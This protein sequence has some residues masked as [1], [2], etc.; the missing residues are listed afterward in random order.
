[1]SGDVQSLR[2][3][4]ASGDTTV[5]R[6]W[7][8]VRRDG[9]RFGFTDH[10]RDLS[11]DGVTF[12]AGSGLSG[13]VIQ[14][15]TGLSVDN[16]AAL[17]TLS[18]P[19]IRAE[20]VEAGRYDGAAVTI[21]RVNWA[22]P[23]A[24]AIEFRGTLGEITRSGIEFEAE[25]RGLAEAL[26]RAEG[27]VFQ[28]QCTAQLGDQRCKVETTRPEY[29]WETEVLSLGPGSEMLLPNGSPYP[30]RWFAGGRVEIRSGEASGLAGSIKQDVSLSE[31][32][33]IVLWEA[34]RARIVPGDL[35]ALIAGCDRAPETCRAKF[36]N[37][38][39][40]RGYPHVPGD[41]WV[42]SYPARAQ[43]RD[44]GRRSS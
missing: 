20:D 7:Q 34:V 42:T 14:K 13:R 9:A 43:R 33:R 36:A 22:S 30:E 21:W 11:F 3:H 19:G 23:E 6:C 28:R 32:R 29:R 5:C 31:G 41:D 8:V 16:S 40:F 4:L 10:D 35:V 44:G 37:F 24:R 26:N 27:L 17:G 25:L 1:M 38:I 39:N 2:A 12:R 18:S 15:A